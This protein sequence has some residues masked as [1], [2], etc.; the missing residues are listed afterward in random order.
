MS[1]LNLD[2]NKPCELDAG[3]LIILSHVCSMET[4][5]Y[6]WLFDIG[7]NENNTFVVFA[8]VCISETYLCQKRADADYLWQEEGKPGCRPTHP[9]LSSDA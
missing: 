6:R 2:S 5:I 4:N 1:P 9:T 7:I 8:F 3:D